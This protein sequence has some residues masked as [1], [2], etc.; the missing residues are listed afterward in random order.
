M[1]IMM[2][3]FT[4]QLKSLQNTKTLRGSMYGLNHR[5]EIAKE[6]IML[7]WC[8]YA[9]VISA[10]VWSSARTMWRKID[11][12]ISRKFVKIEYENIDRAEVWPEAM[13]LIFLHFA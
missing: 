2:I 5:W 10:F 6:V 9:Q 13:K 7:L 1:K 12:A 4:V 8:C 11:A 3:A